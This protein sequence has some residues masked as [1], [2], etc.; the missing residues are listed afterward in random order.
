MNTLLDWRPAADTQGDRLAL[1]NFECTT[2]KPSYGEPHPRPWEW[3]VQADIRQRLLKDTARHAQRDQRLLIADDDDG[4]AA[5]V[6]HAQMKE[7]PSEINVPPGVPIRL[8]VVIAVANRHRRNG[9]AFAD[10]AL[11]ECLYDIL[12]REQGSDHI[13]VVTK[14]DFR[15]LPSMA[16]AQRNGLELEVPGDENDPLGWWYLNLYR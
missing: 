10:H 6:A 4:L 12:D 16:L 8:L 2:P 5:V 7:C 9:G 15:N 14:I 1:Q 3:D 13:V 11:V